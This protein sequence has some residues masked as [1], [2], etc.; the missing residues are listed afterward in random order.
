VLVVRTSDGGKAWTRLDHAEVTVR[1]AVYGD[2]VYVNG[3]TMD[4]RR[5]TD[6]K[7][8]WTAKLRDWETDW[9]K[10]GP[11]AAYANSV[12]ANAGDGTRR[13]DTRDGNQM[14]SAYNNG[15]YESPALLQGNAVWAIDS[16]STADAPQLAVNAVRS[17]DGDERWTLQLPMPEYIRL[18]ANGNRVFVMTDSTLHALTTF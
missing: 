16:S 10:W 12:Y 11:P 2:T 5:L 13:L 15:V 18:A 1:P 14:W 7:L 17:F 8:I 6:G 9:D 3:K 4:A